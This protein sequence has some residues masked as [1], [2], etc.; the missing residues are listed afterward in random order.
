M[1]EKTNDQIIEELRQ[2]ICALEVERNK[3]EQ[4]ARETKRHFTQLIDSS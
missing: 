4:L 1:A 3:A 2:Q